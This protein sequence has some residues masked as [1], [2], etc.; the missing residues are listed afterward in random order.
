MR[1][2]E[3]KVVGIAAGF[4]HVQPYGAVAQ[5]GRAPSLL[6]RIRRSQTEGNGL[7]GTFRSRSAEAIWRAG[8]SQQRLEPALEYRTR[9]SDSRFGHRPTIVGTQLVSIS[10]GN[11]YP[12]WIC[13]AV[14]QRNFSGGVRK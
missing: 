5:S 12:G 10:E 4:G 11:A 6:T 3:T 7:F 14:D 9:S 8:S 13:G 2:V 1:I